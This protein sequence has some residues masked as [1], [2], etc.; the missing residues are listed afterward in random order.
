[1][2]EKP[3]APP[4]V[5]QIPSVQNGISAVAS[6]NAPFLFFDDARAVGYYNGVI[7]VTL[8]AARDL[9]TAAGI[10]IDWAVTGHLRMSIPAAR[11]LRDAIDSA[12]LLA[13]P[14]ATAS[15]DAFGV[16][17]KPN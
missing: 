9:P 6:A 14:A 7:R 2:S 12:L 4:V 11:A 17:A 5:E 3:V 10:G 1:M 15:D 13:T 8:C 16:V